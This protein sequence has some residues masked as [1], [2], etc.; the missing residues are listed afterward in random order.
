MI[1]ASAIYD[2]CRNNS[3]MPKA[4]QVVL[5]RCRNRT[6]RPGINSKSCDGKLRF[7]IIDVNGELK[8]DSD[9]LAA[10]QPHDKHC[11]YYCTNSEL[12]QLVK[13]THKLAKVKGRR[14][15]VKPKDDDESDDDRANHPKANHSN[16]NHSNPDN[17]NAD[18]SISVSSVLG[19]RFMEN[20]GCEPEDDPEDDSE[21]EPSN[22]SNYSPSEPDDSDEDYRVSEAESSVQSDD[23]QI[24]DDNQSDDFVYDTDDDNE[25]VRNGPKKKAA[26]KA[27]LKIPKTKSET[28]AHPDSTKNEPL[29][30]KN[31]AVGGLSTADDQDDLSISP[32]NQSDL[33]PAADQVGISTVPAI[34]WPERLPRIVA[35]PTEEVYK[36]PT[37]DRSEGADEHL[38]ER[39]ELIDGCLVELD[40][41]VDCSDD[42]ANH[43]E[44]MK[45]SYQPEDE[46]LSGDSNES[47][48]R[49]LPRLARNF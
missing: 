20:V 17:S 36:D 48:G 43:L 7:F 5:Y 30:R 18:Q 19:Q 37:N 45:R 25:F 3:Y 47:G 44:S 1:Y 9:N 23:H 38:L 22:T 26:L 32:D 33:P 2:L 24:S 14:W 40:A 28:D 41:L 10:Y 27:A 21:D 15:A 35:R 39:F 46:E 16:A 31:A 34:E 42:L 4:G 13:P 6:K 12:K 29:E 49:K 11:Q 8:V